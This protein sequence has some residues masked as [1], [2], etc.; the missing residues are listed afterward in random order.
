MNISDF[1]IHS[2]GKLD[3]ILVECCRKVITN[4]ELDPDYWGMVGACMVDNQ[5]RKV[6]GVNHK[7]VDGRCHAEVAAIKKYIAKYGTSGLDGAIIVTTLSP[8]STEIDQPGG[9]NCVDYIEDYGI[10]KVYCGYV[11]PTQDSSSNYHHKRF[12]VMETRN[13]QLQNI[14]RKM[15]DTFLPK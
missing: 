15:A 2:T 9:V 4:Q 13:T 6:Y 3:S 11:D 12:H 14:C 5:N 8:C 7:V 1:Q 10:K